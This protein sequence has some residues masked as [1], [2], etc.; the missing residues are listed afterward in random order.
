MDTPACLLSPRLWSFSPYS[1]TAGCHQT[2]FTAT[3]LTFLEFF[4]QHH[5]HEKSEGFRCSI[6]IWI[7]AKV[8]H[9]VSPTFPVSLFGPRFRFICTGVFFTLVFR[10]IGPGMCIPTIPSTLLSVSILMG[11]LPTWDTILNNLLE[12]AK[13]NC[14]GQQPLF[15]PSAWSHFFFFFSKMSSQPCQG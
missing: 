3:K 10:P 9:M 6:W 12:E 11:L 14:H 1:S 5:T 15:P 7:R 13:H 8:G 4:I 2:V